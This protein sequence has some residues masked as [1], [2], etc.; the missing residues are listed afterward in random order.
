MQISAEA[1]HGIPGKSTLSV[2]VQIGKYKVT[3]LLDSGSTQS[4]LDSALVHKL[5]LPVHNTPAQI[6]LVAGGGQL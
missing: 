2:P 5:G 6:V 1:L 4:F 3:A